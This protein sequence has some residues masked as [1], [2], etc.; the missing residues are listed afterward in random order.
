MISNKEKEFDTISKKFRQQTFDDNSDSDFDEDKSDSF[1]NNY[2]NN[3]F[4]EENI[5]KA[6]RSVLFH[7]HKK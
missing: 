6:Y 7:K 3:I 5:Q 1:Q 4:T 2:E